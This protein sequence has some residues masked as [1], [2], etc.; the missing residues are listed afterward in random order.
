[1]FKPVSFVHAILKGSFDQYDFTP[2]VLLT[3]F[4]GY[5]VSGK[6]KVSG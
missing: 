6:Q 4:E 5:K 3:S 2:S 1:M